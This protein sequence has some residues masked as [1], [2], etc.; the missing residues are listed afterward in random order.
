MGKEHLMRGRDDIW[1]PAGNAALSWGGSGI[2]RGSQMVAA[3]PLAARGRAGNE[4]T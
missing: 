3:M 1:W 4:E 2:K